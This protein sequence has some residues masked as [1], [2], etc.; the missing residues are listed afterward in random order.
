VGEELTRPRQRVH[1]AFWLTLLACLLGAA[2]PITC[3]GS[4]LLEWPLAWLLVALATSPFLLVVGT[5]LVARKDG[6]ASVTLAVVA[7]LNLLIGLAG[8]SWVF[9][10]REGIALLIGLFGIP[11][12]QLFVWLAG[13]VVAGRRSG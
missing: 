11:L 2:V 7:G 1:N 9:S 13:A 10:D 3:V 4:A 6:R 12:T 5:A 8:W